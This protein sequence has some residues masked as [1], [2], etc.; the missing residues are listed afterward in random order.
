[1]TDVTTLDVVKSFPMPVLLVTAF[2]LNLSLYML[3]TSSRRSIV[4]IPLQNRA[5][6]LVISLTL[7]AI[8]LTIAL[9]VLNGL[10]MF[11]VI[12][13]AF[14]FV[15]PNP[16]A[17]SR[18]ERPLLPPGWSETKVTGVSPLPPSVALHAA[19]WR[20]E[21]ATPID[22]GAEDRTATMRPPSQRR[23]LMWANMNAQGMMN[24]APYVGHY[25]QSLGVERALVFNYRGVG[26]ST[27]TPMSGSDIIDDTVAM[28]RYLESEHDVNTSLLLIH[29]Q[30]LGA[31]VAVPAAAKAKSRGP[32]VSDRGFSSLHAIAISRLKQPLF[33]AFF[34]SMIS[35]LATGAAMQAAWAGQFTGSLYVTRPWLAT[36]CLTIAGGALAAGIGITPL[37][38]PV[39]QN[40]GWKLDAAT[41]WGNGELVGERIVI[42]HRNDGIIT[43]DSSL[44]LAVIKNEQRRSGRQHKK[45]KHSGRFTR[46]HS[47]CVYPSTS[48]FRFEEE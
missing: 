22:G 6:K 48:A 17:S 46:T 29:G 8:N 5:L 16:H 34:G 31:T 15:V 33:S 24:A 10:I 11:F 23:W 26:A 42:Y 41:P 37:V 2:A 35:A 30:S 25:A 18:G 44:H 43:Y 1:M 21:K 13:G 12:P 4:S 7:G 19:V 3:R 38:A 20:S 27:G 14:S 45:R 39:M 28:I 36:Q 40:L 47:C 9:R 32:V